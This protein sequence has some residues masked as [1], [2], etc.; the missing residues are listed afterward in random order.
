[1]GT[2][3]KSALPRVMSGGQGQRKYNVTLSS[4]FILSSLQ[5]NKNGSFLQ[6]QILPCFP[7]AR[8]FLVNIY[9]LTSHE[10]KRAG[11]GGAV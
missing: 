4:L 5:P 8:I 3:K 1:M 6:K 9:E 2:Y 7:C 11:K 10:A